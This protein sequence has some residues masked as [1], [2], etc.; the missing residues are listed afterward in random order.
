MELGNVASSLHPLETQ[1]AACAWLMV[2]S[3]FG[4][5]LAETGMTE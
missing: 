1:G 4:I 2:R 3:G 5:L